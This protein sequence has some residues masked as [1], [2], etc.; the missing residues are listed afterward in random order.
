MLKRRYNIKNMKLYHQQQKPTDTKQQKHPIPSSSPSQESDTKQQKHPIP[1][2]STSYTSQNDLSES[3]SEDT[4]E[5]DENDENVFHTYVKII[6]S[7][8]IKEIQSHFKNIEKE[9]QNIITAK[10]PSWRYRVF[11]KRFWHAEVRPQ[12]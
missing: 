2:S 8:T 4:C 11:V 6:K 9:L 3:D 7:I 12:I 10:T 5:S 1:S